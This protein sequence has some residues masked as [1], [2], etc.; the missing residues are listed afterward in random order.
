MVTAPPDH[1]RGASKKPR[2]RH[3]PWC[4]H[5]EVRRS[6]SV[7]DWRIRLLCPDCGAQRWIEPDR[8]GPS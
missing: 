2:L 5:P 8:K 3:A 6:T 4:Q 1:A 7:F